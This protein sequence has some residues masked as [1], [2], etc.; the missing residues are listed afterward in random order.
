MLLL[1]VESKKPF[2]ACWP[3][4]TQLIRGAYTKC[5]FVVEISSCRCDR[6]GKFSHPGILSLVEYILKHLSLEGKKKP[7]STIVPPSWPLKQ[8]LVVAM[9]IQLGNFR[10][11]YGVGVQR[12]RNSGFR[13]EYLY[14]CIFSDHFFFA[15]TCSSSSMEMTSVGQRKS[16]VIYVILRFYNTEHDTII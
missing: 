12:I 14:M 16:P 3:V 8:A 7:E 9:S 13:E 2:S 5:G 10:N 4:A 15:Q 6:H 11:L 1:V